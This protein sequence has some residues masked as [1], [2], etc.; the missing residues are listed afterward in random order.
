MNASDILEFWF[1][2]NLEKDPLC[3]AEKWFVKNP[4][5]DSSIS[6]QFKPY[7]EKISGGELNEWKKSP[8]ESLAYI[9]VTDQLP[10]LLTQAIAQL[11]KLTGMSA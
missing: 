11:K 2:K 3:N 1:G 4:E 6:E 10:L 5:F 7:L 8:K 9:I